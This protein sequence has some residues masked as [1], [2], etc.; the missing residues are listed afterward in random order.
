MIPPVGP[1]RAYAALPT[2]LNALQLR[3]RLG[4]ASQSTINLWVKKGLLP[5][6]VKMGRNRLWPECAIVEA[7]ARLNTAGV[8]DA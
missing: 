5:A 1:G 3:Q 6:P 8:G 4:N 2:Y 7:L